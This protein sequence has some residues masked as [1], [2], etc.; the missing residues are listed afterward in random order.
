[1]YFGFSGRHLGFTSSGLPVTSD[2]IYSIN[3]MS[4]DLNDLE[5]IGVS[6]EISMIYSLEDKIHEPALK[7]SQLNRL[8]RP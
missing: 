2:S 5:N 3:D 7:V 1:M 4:R 6:I 8:D